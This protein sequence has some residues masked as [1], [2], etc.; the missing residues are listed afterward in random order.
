M[1]GTLF[2]FFW[3]GSICTLRLWFPNSQNRALYPTDEDLSAHGFKSPLR[4]E[5]MLWLP[6]GGHQGIEG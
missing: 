2:S 1:W 3:A 4:A 5:E 6:E